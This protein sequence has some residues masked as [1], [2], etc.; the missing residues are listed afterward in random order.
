MERGIENRGAGV[1]QKKNVGQFEFPTLCFSPTRRKSK[2]GINI[3]F[4][5]KESDNITTHE[6]GHKMA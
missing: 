2:L 6:R 1:F 4:F 5:G 3:Y